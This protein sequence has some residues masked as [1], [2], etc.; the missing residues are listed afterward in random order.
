MLPQHE[1][2]Q[3]HPLHPEADTCD[4]F[5]DML[6]YDALSSLHSVYSMIFAVAQWPITSRPAAEDNIL[7]GAT[8]NERNQHVPN[9]D[10]LLFAM[11]SDS[12]D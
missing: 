8:A 12:Q 9:R 2:D 7:L 11:S 6:Y 3:A 1:K 10:M 4:A 5:I